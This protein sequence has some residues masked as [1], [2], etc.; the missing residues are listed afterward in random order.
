MTLKHAPLCA[1]LLVASLATFSSCKKKEETNPD[2]PAAQSL[3]TEDNS[4]VK[5]EADQVN[6]DINS[7]LENF[8]SL[9]G[10]RIGA[11]SGTGVKQ[12]CG[13]SI[14]SDLANR[15]ITLNFDGTTPCGS[16]SRSRGGRIEVQL[17]R[18]ARWSDANAQLKVTMTDYKVTRLET[19]KSV[20][21]NGVKT[22][23]NVRGWNWLGY[24][25]GTDSIVY[26]ERG[27]DIQAVFSNGGT[28]V[29]SLCRSTSA[30]LRDR[31]GL[32]RLYIR[33][34]GDTAIG[35][36]ANIDTYGTNRNGQAFTGQLT[37]P[38]SSNE[39]CGLWRPTQGQMVYKAAGNSLTLTAGVN[40]SGDIDTRECAYGYKVAWQLSTGT[41]GSVVKSY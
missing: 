32:K 14:T 19:R 3:Q 40:E 4:D 8:P 24:L 5:N 7:A 17:I 2:V 37:T 28:H 27:R 38:W 26:R 30:R 10:G 18:G 35:N 33:A 21:F 41:S 29:F 12:I 1:V 6:T 16:P 34:S 22:L 9:R 39:Y 23:T 31:A 11:D 13:C 15:K 25:A 36:D 20:T